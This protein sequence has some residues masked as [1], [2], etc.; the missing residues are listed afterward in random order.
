MSD[1]E[2][3]QCNLNERNFNKMG[4]HR[5]TGSSCGL[6]MWD[7]RCQWRPWA[8]ELP[9]QWVLRSG[10]LVAEQLEVNL[11]RKAF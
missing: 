3:I 1:H 5:Q 8:G 6:I 10:V 2:L 4:L 9:P 11:S 7:T